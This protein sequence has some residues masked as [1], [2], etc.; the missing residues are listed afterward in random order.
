[1]VDLISASEQY[2]KKDLAP[3]SVYVLRCRGGRLYTG[4]A[5]D[6][7]RRLAQHQAGTGAKFTRA[8]PPEALLRSLPCISR[9]VALKLEYAIKQLSAAQKQRWLAGAAAPFAARFQQNGEGIWLEA[10]AD[11][12]LEAIPASAAPPSGC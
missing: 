2:P 11:N 4:I 3:W 10:G 9:S 6:V 1:M 5:I 8:H 12:A 7:A